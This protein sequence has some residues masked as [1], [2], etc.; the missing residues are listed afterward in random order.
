MNSIFC[1]DRNPPQ[2]LL[3]IIQLRIMEKLLEMKMKDLLADL[4]MTLM[5]MLLEVEGNL[6]HP[7]SLIVNLSL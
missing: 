6:L 3:Q 7:K 1:L 2:T 5:T 4:Y